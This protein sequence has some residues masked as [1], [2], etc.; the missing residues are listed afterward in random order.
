MNSVLSKLKELN[1]Y[2][3]LW[4]AEQEQFVSRSYSHIMIE[5][6]KDILKTEVKVFCPE[7]NMSGKIVDFTFAGFINYNY[8]RTLG[9]K[10]EIGEDDYCTFQLPDLVIQ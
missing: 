5:L 9:I 2:T 8:E 10:V 7:A 3:Y 6:S 1:F 4:L